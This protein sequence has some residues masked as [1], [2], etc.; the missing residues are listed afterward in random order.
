M[1][2]FNSTYREPN[3]VE[4][5]APEYNIL[6]TESES[7]K[8][9]TYELDSNVKE[10]W[11]LVY[12]GITLAERCTIRSHYTGQKGPYS[13]FSW[14]NPPSYANGGAAVTVRYRK[15]DGFS[16]TPIEDTNGQAW[17]MDLIFE[18]VI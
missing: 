9:Q 18:K 5:L 7:F 17:N 16:E 2:D 13:S 14:T 15:V 8:A 10:A 1:A 11:R 12:R 3:W 6:Q 4:P